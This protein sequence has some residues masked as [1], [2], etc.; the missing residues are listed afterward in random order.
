MSVSYTYDSKNNL[1]YVCPI[2]VVYF[3]DIEN[4]LNHLC[5]DNNISNGVVNIVD[6]KELSD[7]ALAQDEA[8]AIHAEFARY[9]AAKLVQAHIIVA[10]DDYH[11]GVAEMMKK[12]IGETMDCHIVESR[13]A[14]EKLASTLIEN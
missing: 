11:R 6:L 4:T 13:N 8:E 5:Q 7:F 1:V 10:Y 9:S 2:D 3:H 12:V 14:A